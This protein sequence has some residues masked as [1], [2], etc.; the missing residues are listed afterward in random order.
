MEV[1]VHKSFFKF[2]VLF[3]GFLFS[4]FGVFVFIMQYYEVQVPDWLVFII[5]GL[6]IFGVVLGEGLIECEQCGRNQFDYEIMRAMKKTK[7]NEWLPNECVCGIQRYEF[8][9]GLK[10]FFSSAEKVIVIQEGVNASVSIGFNGSFFWIKTMSE[11]MLCYAEPDAEQ[12]LLDADIE[13]AILGET[14]RKAFSASK[15]VSVPEFQKIFASGIVQEKAEERRKFIMQQYGYKN[16]RAL[17]KGMLSCSV[18]LKNEEIKLQ[19]TR[20]NGIDGYSADTSDYN[21]I[22]SNN[23]SDTELALAVKECLKHCKAK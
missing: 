7:T 18:Y 21:A 9:E 5:Y 17:F 19:A 2:K 6:M 22:I 8:W 14:I 3:T 10:A 16:K 12:H 11:G 1:V 20:Q 4:T 15:V 23:V 13:D